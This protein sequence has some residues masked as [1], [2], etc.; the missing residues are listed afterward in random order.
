MG[1]I[2]SSEKIISLLNKFR[3]SYESNFLSDRVAIYFLKN[4]KTVYKYINQVKKG[5]DYFKK[6]I[7]KLG[8][9]F[10]GGQSNF[11]LVNFKNEKITERIYQGLFRKHIYV[12]GKY[13]S[14]LNKCL[15]FTCGPEKIMRKVYNEI[16]KI[17]K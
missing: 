14:P 4:I 17:I 9:N 13:K 11:L 3:L 1:Y 6:K 5:R 10:I 2:V 16:Y 7:I 15:L 12:K 8:F